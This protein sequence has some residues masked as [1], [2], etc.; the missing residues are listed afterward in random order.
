MEL[1]NRCIEALTL[2]PSP[3]GEGSST[4]FPLF[5]MLQPLFEDPEC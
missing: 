4:Q 1:L 2:N 5:E 3:F